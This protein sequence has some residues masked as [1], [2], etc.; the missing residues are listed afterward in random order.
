[1]AQL[2]TRTRP[3]RPVDSPILRLT[4][5]D[6]IKQTRISERRGDFGLSRFLKQA[7]HRRATCPDQAATRNS[8][9]DL[10]QSCDILFG[11]VRVKPI[12]DYVC[13]RSCWMFTYMHCD[14]MKVCAP[15]SGNK[16]CK[17]WGKPC[18]CSRESLA[19]AI[20]CEFVLW[21]QKAGIFAWFLHVSCLAK[22]GTWFELLEIRN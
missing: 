4:V 12:Q 16:C 13:N 3:V 7:T 17:Q 6:L 5:R 9:V 11:F 22:A 8:Q 15:F 10:S 19:I 21:W 20:Y 2:Q 14:C 1:M 18:D